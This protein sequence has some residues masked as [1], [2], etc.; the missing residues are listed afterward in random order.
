[1]TEK[2]S[3]NHDL[4][5]KQKAFRHGARHLLEPWFLP[6][7]EIHI[8]DGMKRAEELHRDG[9]GI[10]ALITHFS[11]RDPVQAMDV[12]MKSKEFVDVPIT[13]PIARHQTVKGLVPPVG[14]RMGVDMHPVV[15][16]QTME[17]ALT[18]GNP[19]MLKLGDGSL[20]YVR[21]ATKALQNGEVVIMAP[22]T[23]RRPTLEYNGEDSV[24]G[25]LRVAGKKNDKI[26][27][28]LMTFG[29]PGTENYAD[30]KGFNFFHSYDVFHG[31][32]FT[33]TEALELS[34]ANAAK[35]GI[36]AGGMDNIDRFVFDELEKISPFH[37]LPHSKEQVNQE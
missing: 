19:E 34:E 9:Y 11:R 2:D 24:R 1:M 16:P 3:V 7:E 21:A 18:V 37:Y 22:Q 14:R 29:I 13:G 23:T 8:Q 4:G 17:K 28:H 10:L 15:T 20:G 31:P 6:S 5:F 30:T 35:H 25:L 32:T 26:G 36:E 12:F 27:I 33:L